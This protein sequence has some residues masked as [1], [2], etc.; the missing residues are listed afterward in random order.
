MKHMTVALVVVLGSGV[1]HADDKRASGSN[2]APASGVLAAPSA[3]APASTGRSFEPSMLDTEPRKRAKETLTAL[4]VKGRLAK[5]VVRRYL[6]RRDLMLLV[7][8]EIVQIR[9]SAVRGT[10][11]V[12]FVIDEHGAVTDVS[13]SGFG[14][15][16]VEGCVRRTFRTMEF[17]VPATG[18]AQVTAK[19]TYAP[20]PPPPTP[21]KPIKKK[22]LP[23][24]HGTQASN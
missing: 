13:A 18:R 9:D 22:G 19:I 14:N 17:P 16:Q 12:A 7:C 20:P 15:D 5:D 11:N 24:V 1:V 8:Y 23:T 6:H 2:E 4:E 10:V 3:A 21:R